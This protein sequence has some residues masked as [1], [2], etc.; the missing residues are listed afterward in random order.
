MIRIREYREE[1]INAIQAIWNEVIEEGNSFFW[2]ESFSLDKIRGILERQDAVLCAEDTES[3]EV[4]GFY[5]LHKNFPGRGRMSP[6]RYMQSEAASETGVSAE[7]W[8]CIRW[9][10]PS[11]AGT[12]RSSSTRSCPPI[13]HPSSCGRASDSSGRE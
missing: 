6:M 4:A 3:G 8:R 12:G 9:R 2:T 7:R 11:A 1:D 10:R 5:I 13:R